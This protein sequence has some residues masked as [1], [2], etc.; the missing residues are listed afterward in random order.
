MFLPFKIAKKYFFSSKKKRFI[1]FISLISIIGVCVGT[2]TLI[3]VLS[4]FNGLEDLNR[5]IFNSSDPD[6][7]I[8]AQKGKSFQIEAGILNQVEEIKGVKNISQIIEENAL[9]KLDEDQII[10]HLKGVDSSYQTNTKLS[11]TTVDGLLVTRFEGLPY[12]FVGGGV[13]TT[14]N[15]EVQNY[16]KPLELWFPKNQKVNILNP[17]ENINRL[18]L[19][20]SG[21]FA[22]EQQFDNYVF[23]P[24]EEMEK[25]TELEGKRTAIEI[26]LNDQSELPNI[27]KELKNIL[28]DKFSVKNRDEQNEALFRAIKVEK[29]FI[30]IALLFII[31]IASFNIFFSLSML[32]LDKKDDI[33]TLAALGADKTKIQ[34]IFMIEGALVGFTGALVGILIGVGVCLSQIHFGWLKMGMEFAIV[35]AYPVKLKIT[36]IV[37]TFIGIFFIT[38]IACYFPSKKALNFTKN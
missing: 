37:L 7:K 36:D 3:I 8:E 11:S 22:L 5:Q 23:I 6:L 4:V 10:V 34:Q 35:D 21:V 20:V 24:I 38:I 33:A 17:E 27:Q 2:A 12:A 13:Y 29:L 16:L 28:G 32:V 14:L 18:S 15:L 26:S 30:F 25:L 1:H 31:G 19:P 9:A